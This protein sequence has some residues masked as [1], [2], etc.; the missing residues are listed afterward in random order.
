MRNSGVQS[1]WVIREGR[2]NK[3]YP[4][5]AGGG[6]ES[7]GSTLHW[8]A[9]WT[10]NK[11]HLT[12]ADYHHSKDLS[13]E[14]HT[15]GLYWSEDRLY[16][17]FDDPKNIVLDVDH[18]RQSYW[19]KGQF[20]SYFENLWESGSKAAP[21]DSEFYL[22]INLAVGG[23]NSYFPDGV[24][25]KPWTNQSPNAVNEFYA[26]KD[27][28]YRTWQNPDVSFQIDSVKVWSFN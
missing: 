14:F 21:F 5:S 7:F 22:I 18:S 20:P 27:N 10:S 12:H 2:G 25:G 9:D 28:W 8:G 19:E 6:V 13:D 3:N 4:Q 16:T 11:Y 17:Y 1:F 23:T 26:A 24:G 15:Y